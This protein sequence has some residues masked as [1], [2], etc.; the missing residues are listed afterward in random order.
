[1][2]SSCTDTQE[3]NRTFD[4][5]AYTED[6]NQ[7]VDSIQKHHPQ[8]YE[9]ITEDSFNSLV[10]EKKASISDATT[11]GEFI[12]ICKTII[13]AVGCSH[14]QVG[15][16]S[17]LGEI[18]IPPSILFPM[19]VK[20]IDSNLY[21]IDPLSNETIIKPGAEILSINS[22]SVEQ[23]KREMKK[24]ISSDGYNQ[25]LKDEH[26][27]FD[28]RTFCA[29]QLHFPKKYM[30]TINDKE[31]PKEIELIKTDR[32]IK[33]HKPI[34]RENRLRFEIVSNNSLAIITIENFIFYN[35][36]FS[37]FQAFIDDCFGQIKQNKIEEL[38]I[39]IRDNPGGDPFCASY[40]MQHFTDKP[41]RYY[42]EGTND[43]YSEIIRMIPPHKNR[44][45]KKPY[46]LINGNCE[47]AS[48]QFASLVRAHDIGV[49]VGQETGS[50]YSCNSNTI[51]FSLDNTGIFT[52]LATLTFQTN[53]HGFSKERGIAPDYE[54][55]PEISDLL[56]GRDLEMEKVINLINN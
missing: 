34:I 46:I 9:F 4:R 23:L 1:M 17:R 41:F 31:T 56:N 43:Y 28:F 30:V 6:L 50:T 54:I 13:A 8:P 25:N 35:E 29:F 33:E 44:F 24:V 20:Y 38:V 18:N 32:P 39:D 49:F 40:L 53:V 15:I 37:I 48:G 19:E 22:I 11:L 16:V 10:E 45:T 3:I 42:R 12:W 36:D 26:L 47:S 21:V 52:N 55:K 2:L 51:N 7:L 14:S 27:N 5:E